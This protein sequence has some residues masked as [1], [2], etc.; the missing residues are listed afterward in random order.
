MRTSSV[1]I[2]SFT[3]SLQLRRKIE[4]LGQHQVAV[5]LFHGRRRRRQA[6]RDAVEPAHRL[7]RHRSAQFAKRHVARRIAAHEIDEPRRVGIVALLLRLRHR[8]HDIAM[9]V[10]DGQH[11]GRADN[12]DLKL[13]RPRPARSPAS[14]RKC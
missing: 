11:A 13:N 2:G 12:A 1:S 9:R 4:R 7:F 5:R 6:E 10:V 8:E 3:G 14:P